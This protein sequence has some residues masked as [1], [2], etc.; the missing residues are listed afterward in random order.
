MLMYTRGVRS[1]SAHSV[2]LDFVSLNCMLV[3]RASIVILTSI[4]DSNCY[5]T[6]IT[7]VLHIYDC[8]V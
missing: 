7:G 1:Y 2:R 4:K 5:A 6:V 8:Y 3:D